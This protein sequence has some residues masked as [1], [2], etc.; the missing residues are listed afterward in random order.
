MTCGELMES[1]CRVWHAA[2][3]EGRHNHELFK[4]VEVLVF[5]RVHARQAPRPVAVHTFS[6]TAAQPLHPCLHSFTQPS[7]GKDVTV[8]HV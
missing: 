8:G 2:S 5:V 1:A 7:S 6:N 4:K 3:K